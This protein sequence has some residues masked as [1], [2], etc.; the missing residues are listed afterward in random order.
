MACLAA[1]EGGEQLRDDERRGGLDRFGLAALR[2]FRTALSLSIAAT[3][4]AS[5]TMLSDESEA[6]LEIS[7]SA[8]RPLNLS[9]FSTMRSLTAAGLATPR[10]AAIICIA[11]LIIPSC[12]KERSRAQEYAEAASCPCTLAAVPSSSIR[13]AS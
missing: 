4:P 3:A 1:L 13:R 9:F 2:K 11:A 10:S 6:S 12:S 7:L 5:P 8:G